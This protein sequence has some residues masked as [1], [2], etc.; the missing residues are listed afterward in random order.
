MT[1]KSEIL[2]E[3]SALSLKNHCPLGIYITP[4]YLQHYNSTFSLR[5]LCVCVVR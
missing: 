5:I 4:N 2:M 1:T 3:Y